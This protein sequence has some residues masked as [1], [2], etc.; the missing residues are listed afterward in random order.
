MNRGV[1][2]VVTAEFLGTFLLVFAGAG[3]IV[4]DAESQG[5]VSPIG[6]G[7]SFG[8][9]VMAAIIIFGSVS[10]AHINP[11]VTVSFCVR[12]Y[13]SVP[14]GFAYVGAQLAGAAT[15]AAVLRVLFDRQANLGAT[16]PSNGAWQ[17]LVLEVLLTFFLVLV[18]LSVAKGDRIELPMAAIAVGAYVGLA[19]T[20]AGPISG[21]SMNPARSFGP[22]LMSGAWTDHWVYWVGPLLGALLAAAL[23][24]VLRFPPQVTE[25]GVEEN[26]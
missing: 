13:L 16:I 17:A 6:I 15:A 11:A 21:A 10:G 4:I 12:G 23:F 25:I 24:Q 14:K 19:A 22:A 8:L 26:L 1:L 2:Q 3:A 18:V 9:A 20:F 7:L 5:G